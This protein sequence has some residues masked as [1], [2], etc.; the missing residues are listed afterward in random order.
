MCWEIKTKL[1]KNWR[2]D[3]EN[4]IKTIPLINVKKIESKQTLSRKKIKNENNNKI[5]F[6]G[7]AF[8]HVYWVQ[9]AFKPLKLGSRDTTTY[10]NVGLSIPVSFA[11]NVG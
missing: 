11:G 5:K 2:R 10:I 1:M 4:Q 9:V 3:Q 8:F 7:F 6:R